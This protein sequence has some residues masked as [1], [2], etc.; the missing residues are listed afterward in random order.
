MLCHRAHGEGRR[1][2]SEYD[3][4]Y[5]W[6]RSI[7][8]PPPTGATGP[9]PAL[10]LI[11]P[12]G[13][14]DARTCSIVGCARDDGEGVQSPAKAR[15]PGAAAGRATAM[16]EFDLA[17]FAA[18]FVTV[19]PLKGAAVF[20]VLSEGAPL[21]EQRRVAG[22]ATLIASGLRLVFALFGDDL[23]RGIGISLAGAKAPWRDHAPEGRPRDDRRRARQSA[24]GVLRQGARGLRGALRRER[25]VTSGRGSAARPRLS[26]AR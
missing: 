7:A 22:R 5:L 20:A 16:T 14:F 4:F 8:G 17:S 10:C 11:C 12:P 21:A 13:V 19:N 15:R 2:T 9:G 3:P 6:S 18:L 23:L 1:D 25:R 26:S 24:H